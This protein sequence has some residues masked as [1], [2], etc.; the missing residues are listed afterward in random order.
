M[1]KSARWALAVLAVPLMAVCG[2]TLAQNYPTK[3]IK[4]VVPFGA[5]S[6]T[7]NG[8]RLL[9]TIIGP[10]LGQSIVV[11]NKPG[12]NGAI[13]AQQVARAAPDGYTLLMG[14]NSTHGGT[15]ALMKEPGYDPIKDFVPV[16]LVGIF[17]GF[18]VVNPSV[19]A[20]TAA[21]L[22]AY[23]KANPG[24]VAYA[25][26]NTTSIAMAEAFRSELKLDILRVPY[27]SNPPA[28]TD[29]IGGRVQMMFPDISTSISHVKSG[30][31]RAL[32]VV[33]LGERSP[34]APDVPTINES[35]MPKFHLVGWIG[36]FAPAGTPQPIIDRI[37]AEIVKA[38]QEPEFKQKM[39]TLGA[40]AKSMPPAEFKK[41]VANEVVSLPKLL[42]DAGVTPE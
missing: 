41:F 33:S 2:A 42:R 24:K 7:D 6:G 8:T 4:I 35:V 17:P 37:A 9:A 34:L 25:S 27:Q 39:T 32:A 18:L 16:S 40:E 20:K 26:G 29:V 13:A 31:L 21:E 15:L 28:L 19:P 1:T 38:T 30:S 11:E 12:A 14:T 23:I 5:G 22:V 10:R 36:L 3:P